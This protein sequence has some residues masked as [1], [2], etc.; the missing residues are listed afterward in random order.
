VDTSFF[1]GELNKGYLLRQLVDALGVR[2]ALEGMAVEECTRRAT[3]EQLSALSR[4][5]SKVEQRYARGED[6]SEF[7]LKFHQKLVSLSGNALLTHMLKNLLRNSSGIW[8][9][10]SPDLAVI[11]RAS[12]PAHRVMMERMLARDAAGAARVHHDYM[13]REIELIREIET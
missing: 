9:I 11:L 5:L 3:D 8:N 7:D 4:L 13:S 10:E 1:V 6:Q 12:I 2:K